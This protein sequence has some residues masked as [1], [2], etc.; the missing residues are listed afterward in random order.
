MTTSYKDHHLVIESKVL[1]KKIEDFVAAQIGEK[2]GNK[3]VSLN[4][5]CREATILQR[6]VASSSLVE[7][8]EIVDCASEHCRSVRAKLLLK[9]DNAIADAV[10][11]WNA[12]KK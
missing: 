9:I 3:L 7:I 4:I 11:A 12:K 1:T 2:R 5:S 8:G 10:K 6:L